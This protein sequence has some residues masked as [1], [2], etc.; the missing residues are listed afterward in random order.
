MDLRVVLSD[1][2]LRQELLDRAGELAIGTG[3][4]GF[5]GLEGGW[6][7]DRIRAAAEALASGSESSV[8]AELEA[9]IRRFGRPSYMV[10][11]G[12]FRAPPDDF[13]ESKT[14]AGVLK[15]ARR[16]LE[17]AIPSVGR[18]DLRNHRLEWVGTGWI[19]K[20]RIV[21][22]NRHVAA[23]FSRSRRGGFAFR[24]TMSGRIASPSVDFVREHRR[25]DEHRF[26]VEEVLWIEPEP[27]VDVAVMKIAATGE[28][29]G[30]PPPQI[31]LMTASEIRRLAV[32]AWIAVIGFPAR[33]SRNDRQ[34][35]QRIF[36]G[37]FNV[38][39]LA[40][41]RVTAF[42]ADEL[43]EHDAT[44]LNGSSGSVILDLATGKALGLHFGGIEGEHN[45]AVRSDR[46]SRI[47]EKVE[48]RGQAG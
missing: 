12:T 34:D 37:I 17:Q 3:H 31:P 26:L 14:I 21:V 1:P 16:K 47:V 41:G 24:E 27:A 46:L 35:Q 19:V 4:A 20:P 25:A 15:T 28:R 36:D 13:P 43:V 2:E 6:D 8:D 23:E 9:I 18:I 7:P 40:P 29:G 38:K 45:L 22:T 39:R 5:E 10:Q 42:V 30:T 44:T 33:D 11:R 48:R 32:G